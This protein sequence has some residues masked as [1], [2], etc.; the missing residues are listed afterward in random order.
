LHTEKL[1]LCMIVR[2]EADCIARCLDSVSHLV[3][4]M[5]VVDTGSTDG[6][7]AICR[8]RGANVYPFSWNDDFSEARNY[9]LSLA[10]GEW[11]LWLDADEE[12]EADPEQFRKLMAA[13]A[14]DLYSFRLHN[15]YGPR[16]DRNQ[17]ISMAH[18][19][20]FRNRNGFRFRNRIHET[21]N[22][23]EVLPG[24][25]RQ[26]RIGHA[27]VTIWHYGYLDDFVKRKGKADRN[28]SLL[29]EELAQNENDPWLHYHLASEYYRIRQFH[30]SFQHVNRSI[31]LF[32]LANLTPPSL[33][34]KL[35][36]SILL[37]L[38]SFEGAYP[39]IEKA[40]ALYPDYVD[41]IF[42]K[43]VILFYLD[44]PSEAI[45]ALDRCLEIGEENLKHLTQRGL[46]SFHAW[47]YKGMCYEK[48]GD[49]TKAAACYREALTI[50]PDHQESAA[51]L[52][53]LQ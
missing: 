41:L 52:L 32:L 49:L 9:S 35:K 4:E 48:T 27:S 14:Y 1:S 45:G 26:K 53:R 31:V 33:L 21:L 15:F 23:D 5:I 28:V 47:H 38:G 25:D 11:I 34:Y 16:A 24:P 20:L 44:K 17:V 22:V 7:D 36:Y 39:A 29:K 40:I 3:D 18:P 6:T 37:S 19:R 8:S 43:A 51:A 13:E 30:L 12:I 42:Y 10:Q 50:N 46:G 2:N